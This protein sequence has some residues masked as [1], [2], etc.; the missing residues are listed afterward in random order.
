[1]KKIYEKSELTFALM[2]IGIYCVVQSLSNPINEMLG[3]ENAASALFCL[4]QGAVLFSFMKKNRLLRRYGLCKAAAPAGKFLYYIPLV[5]LATSNFWNG[6]AVNLSPAPMFFYILLMLGVGFTEEV[7]FRGLL[8]HA[9]RKDRVKSAIVISSLTFGLG[10]LMNLTNGSGMELAENLLQVVGATLYGFLF[11][12]L[13][14]RG[15]SLIPAIL[16]HCAINISSA[17][18]KETGLTPEKRI[19][20]MVIQLAIIAGYVCFLSRTLPEPQKEE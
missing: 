19:G 16:T 11:V 12:M 13:F 6:V 7:I 2:W 14:Y 18:V 4:I 1:M 9:L 3:M 5:I 17:F 15:G 20:F 8:F 10:H